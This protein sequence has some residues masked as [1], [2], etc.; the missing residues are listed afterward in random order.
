[1]KPL[2]RSLRSP[3]S[4]R[5]FTLPAV[6]VVTSAMLILSVG[7]LAVVSIERK[8]ARSYTDVKRSELAARAGLEEFRAVLRTET[9]NDDFL[10]VGDT[11]DKPRTTGREAVPSLYLAR[12]S[13]G[14]DQ[15][16]YRYLPLFSATGTPVTNNKLDAPEAATLVGAKPYEFKTHPWLDPIQAAWIPVKDKKGQ[17]VARYAYW[18]EDL[19]GNLDA[20]TAGNL[21]G[22]GG[23]PARNVYPFP[24]PGVNPEPLAKDQPKLNQVAIHVLDPASGDTP[25]GDLTRKLIDRRALMISPDSIV[26]ATD[27]K[28]PLKRDQTTGLLTDPLAQALERNASPV[29]QPYKEQPVVPFA[30]GI[31]EKVAGLPKKNLN[32][33]LAK[34]RDTAVNEFADWIDKG[35]PNFK[36]RRGGFPDD[37][38]KTLAANALDYADTDNDPTVKNDYRGI[39][40]YPFMSELVL[41]LNYLGEQTVDG[42]RILRWRFKLF[43][44]LWNLTDKPVTGKSRLSYEVDL[45]P[46][47]IGA[48]TAGK[49]F[50]DPT[51]LDNAARSTHNLVK[52]DGKYWTQPIDVS[53]A[54]DQYKFY[55]YASVI[56]NLDVGSSSTPIGTSFSLSEVEGARGQ[57]HKWNDITVERIDKIVHDS[58]GLDFNTKTPESQGKAAIPAHSYGPYG[59]FYNNMGD[60]RMSH[61]IRTVSLGANAYPENC[62]PN[63]RNIRR[64]TIYDGDSGTKPKFYGRVMPSEWPDGGHDGPV[65]SWS[66]S[67]ADTQ[68]PTA[69]SY[70]AGL[71]AV[72]AQ[73]APQR[74]SNLGRFYS[75]TELGNIYDPIMWRPTYPSASDSTTLLSGNMPA[76]KYSFPDVIVKSIADPIYGGGNTLR[77]GRPEHPRFDAPGLRAAHLLD[78]FHAGE[79]TS[80]NAAEREGDVVTMT[81]SVNLNTASRDALRA[82]AAG[83]L[84]QDPLLSK[85]T[86]R[87]HRG[88]PYMSP[89]TQTVSDVGSPTRAVAADRIADA[90]IASRP[91]SCMGEVSAASETPR[92]AVP[93]NE[94]D[95]GAVFGNRKMY[96]YGDNLQWSDSAAEEVFARV[97]DAATLR[98]RNFRVWIVGQALAA[99]TSTDPTATQEVLAET[100]KVFTVFADPG[101]RKSDGTIDPA[102]YSPRIIHENDF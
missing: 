57:A 101:E 82:L 4:P 96:S 53:L 60:P 94:T 8:T 85:V 72:S 68:E 27:L 83:I 93:G 91:F 28:A 81:G 37:Y 55:E 95:P 89:N 75:A 30:R 19:Q 90:I 62:S 26:A 97:H 13:G 22:T 98:S 87:T 65:G 80:E 76:G 20:K 73:N 50:D 74:I 43:G 92:T 88:A 2:H 40:G 16:T 15:V 35:L 69:A 12:G 64:Q 63:R 34:N 5:G 48:G 61:Y 3:R 44:E 33:L 29:I 47:A 59:T 38:L 24:A 41:Q 1:M 51:L 66:I 56:Y 42:R 21:A 31:S 67:T 25:K 17:I 77:I 58:Q 45:R 102:K 86:S 46:G 14:G 6:L 52:I 99:P 18:V 49:P 84:G 71:P 78:L 9:A 39:D 11:P 10:V 54:P 36:D 32:A 79:S 7:L 100:R 23:Q 70:L